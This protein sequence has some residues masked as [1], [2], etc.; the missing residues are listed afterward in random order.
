MLLGVSYEWVG[1][2]NTTVFFFGAVSSAPWRDKLLLASWWS[3]FCLWCFFYI[4]SGWDQWFF[5][6][7]R[8]LLRIYVVVAT[9]H[10]IVVRSPIFL[11]KKWRRKLWSHCTVQRNN[12]ANEQKEVDVI[13]GGGGCGGSSIW[14]SL[15]GV[16]WPKIMRPLLDKTIWGSPLQTEHCSR[17]KPLLRAPAASAKNDSEPERSPG[18]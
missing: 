16:K 9:S 14:A 8:L 7:P 10:H 15:I 11:L 1:Q 12:C 4:F 2:R 17:N 3:A 18:C 13:S 6:S 5:Y